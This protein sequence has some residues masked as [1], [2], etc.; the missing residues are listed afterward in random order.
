MNAAGGD[1]G[2]N[3]VARISRITA[4]WELTKR[5]RHSATLGRHVIVVSTDPL[6][7]N[8]PPYHGCMLNMDLNQITTDW[9]LQ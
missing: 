9:G 3:E 7:T 8:L 6:V 2:H 1:G 4:A 5:I